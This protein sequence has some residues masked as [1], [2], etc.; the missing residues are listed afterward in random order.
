MVHELL[1]RFIG[2]L[3]LSGFDMGGSLGSMVARDSALPGRLL[4]TPPGVQEDDDVHWNFRA[5]SD[6][7]AAASP[8]AP[9][10]R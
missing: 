2:L 7:G 4:R 6:P 9:P 10:R 8:P 5:P 3:D 1:R